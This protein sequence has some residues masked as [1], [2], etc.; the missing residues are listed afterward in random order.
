MHTG[1]IG[2]NYKSSDLHLRELLAKAVFRCF[3]LEK[4]AAASLSCVL[5]MTCNRTEVYFSAPNL[6]EA[7][8]EILQL[9][10]GEIDQPFE[11][12]LY[13]YFGIDCFLHLAK[14]TAG[15][16]SV[17]LAET[18]IQRQVKAAYESACIDYTLPSC[19]HF[20][21]Q[22][23]L[24]IGKSIRTRIPICGQATLEDVIFQ[25][26]Q[27]LLK[28][29]KE[30]RL[31]F[32]GNSEINRKILYF[33]R[34]KGVKHMSLCTRTPQNA[35]E[36]P[37][38]VV[39]WTELPFWH[40]YDLVICGTYQHDYLITSKQISDQNNLATKLICDLSVPRTVDPNLSRH[41]QITLM[42]IEELGHLT[43]QKVDGRRCALQQ[44]E[45]GIR[46]AV[47]LQLFLFQQ[48]EQK[49]LLC[50]S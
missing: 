25:L 45:E 17:I 49:R 13:S 7:H 5:L 19:I 22:K 47:T 11:H 26:G 44:A 50:A 6:A 34:K 21:F 33:L 23:C 20:M 9:L 31:L 43:L 46:E 1:V 12:K 3:G 2:I 38:E 10:R 41:P 27:C 18:E 15:L 4:G 48:K 32:V 24:K 28:D 42:N 16:D 40:H 35:G 36:L 8:S 37:C 14:V 29:M 39:G 30:T